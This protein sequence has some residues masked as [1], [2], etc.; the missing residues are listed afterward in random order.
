MEY[1]KISNQTLIEPNAFK[2]LGACTKRDDATKIGYFGSGLKYGIAV[3]LRKNIDFVVYSGLQKIDISLKSEIFREKAFNVIHIAGEKTSLT[4]DMGIDWELWQAIREVY[5][6]ALDETNSHHC[7]IN[8][9]C[10]KENETAF[11][12]SLENKD[13]ADLIQKWD[14]YFSFNRRMLVGDENKIF[15]SISDKVNVYRK[16]IRC[17]DEFY[18]S[19]YD[20]DFDNISINESRV[21]KWGWEVKEK[22]AELWGKYATKSMIRNI[23]K[24]L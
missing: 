11:Y 23:S 5:C 18:A 16:G 7:I 15:D 17:Y 21:V 2:L 4:T 6:N 22:L 8:E 13:M 1:L 14:T 3:L 12:I 19:L 24:I 20:Y 9:I 10:P